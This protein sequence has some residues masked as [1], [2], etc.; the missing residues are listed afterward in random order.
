MKHFLKFCP[1]HQQNN[2]TPE[3][4]CKSLRTG[5][6]GMKGIGWPKRDQARILLQQSTQVTH[7]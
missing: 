2:K 4:D 6:D 5:L 7:Q 1:I 3:V